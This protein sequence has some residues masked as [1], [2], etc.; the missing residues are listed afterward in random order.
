[1]NWFKTKVKILIVVFTATLMTVSGYAVDQTFTV[2]IRILAALSVAIDQHLDFGV[3][4]SSASAQNI[5]VAPTDGNA[6]QIT[7]TGEPSAN[8]TV[9][10]VESSITLNDGGTNTLNVD[11]FTVG[12]T[13]CTGGSATLDGSGS[14]NSCRVGAIARVIGGQASATYSGSATVQVT[15]N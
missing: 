12:G 3:V 1:M 5:P 13:G 14:L 2:G 7:I 6:A 8:V 4:E 10:V 9:G 11:T 15:Y